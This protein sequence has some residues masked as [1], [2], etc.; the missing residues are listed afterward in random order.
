MAEPTTNY[1]EIDGEG[2]YIEDTEARQGVSDNADAI[3]AINAKIPAS[4]SA[5]NKMATAADVALTRKSV[6][7]TE[8]YLGGSYTV[9]QFGKVVMV[10]V[11]GLS[12]RNAASGDT[13]VLSG[14][15]I[16]AIAAYAV[17]FNPG[18][19]EMRLC[20]D[21][22]QLLVSGGPAVNAWGTLVYISQ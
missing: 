12:N 13:P 17:C 2:K 6:T 21:N 15:P 3:A 20:A 19:T 10:T 5:A 11:Q 9:Y 8:Y 14:L 7:T 22:G 16:P 4:A 1:I 18:G